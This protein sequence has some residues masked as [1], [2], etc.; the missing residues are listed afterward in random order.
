MSK[1]YDLTKIIFKKKKEKEG[2]EIDVKASI[3]LIEECLTY[4]D[5]NDLEELSELKKQMRAAVSELKKKL[6]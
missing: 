1:L 4:I 6:E 5:F 3:I 2:I